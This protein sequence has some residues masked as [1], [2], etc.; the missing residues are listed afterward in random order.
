MFYQILLSGKRCQTTKTG[1]TAENKERIRRGEGNNEGQR[2][3]SQVGVS[4]VSGVY[5]LQKGSHL[6]DIEE[7][8]ER[9]DA[10]NVHAAKRI[11]FRMEIIPAIVC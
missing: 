6:D 1:G 11:F 4:N 2:S 10:E 7:C 9:T 3:T 8:G 5:H